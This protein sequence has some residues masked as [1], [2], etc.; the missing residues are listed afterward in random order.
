MT[1]EIGLHSTPIVAK[2]RRRSSAPRIETGAH[3]A[4]SRRTSRATSAASTC[5]PASGCGSSTRFRSR[6]SSATTRGRTSRGRYTGNTGV[7]AQITVDEELGLAYLPVE[8][9]TGDYYGGH[10]PGNNLFGES[11]VAVDL[12]DRQAQV[13]LPARAPR[14]LGHGHS[15]ARRFSP[16]SPSTA[17]R[18]RRSRS[19]PSRRSSTC[20]IA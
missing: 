5:A 11:L 4:T 14:H 20:S 3:A 17:G 7:W 10:R 12:Q 16:T 1:G 15:R 8:T 19:R 2:R 9:P 6:A 13:A 18:S